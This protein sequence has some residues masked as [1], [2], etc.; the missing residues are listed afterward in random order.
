MKTLKI[1]N[2]LSA[3]IANESCEYATAPEEYAN[4]LFE[5]LEQDD[6]RAFVCGKEGQRI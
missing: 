6:W 5:A 1:Y 3:Q 2:T 4:E